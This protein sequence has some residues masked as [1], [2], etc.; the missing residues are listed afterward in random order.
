[1]DVI[2]DQNT[3]PME[4]RVVRMPFQEG[5]AKWREWR[6]TGI[7][8]SDAAVIMGVSPWKT[9]ERLWEEKTGRRVPHPP[10]RPMLHGK[11]ME[12]R[13]RKAYEDRT[14]I[15]VTPMCL[16][17]PS[18]PWMLASA[19]GISFEHSV[20]LEIKCPRSP[21]DHIAALRGR[22]PNHYYPQVQHLLAVSTAGMCHYWSYRRGVGAL[23]EVRPD[24]AYIESLVE[25]EWRFWHSV[26]ERRHPS[27]S[28]FRDAPQ[29]HA[30]EP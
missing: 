3:Q 26:T 21:R 1:M 25:R 10:T 7:G 27:E 5:T 6:D 15:S 18:H 28:G 2:K 20:V 22:I 12:P 16:R 13:A 8:G 23:V 11:R 4:R 24:C 14:G 9:V 30:G 19:D 29:H 17:H